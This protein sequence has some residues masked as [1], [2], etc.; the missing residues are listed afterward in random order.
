MGNREA[1]TI[2]PRR[3]HPNRPPTR[4]EPPMTAERQE[5]V[6]PS[7]PFLAMFLALPV[8]GLA[9]GP[10]YAA[11][12]FG[13]A[14]ALALLAA[15]RHHRL[16]A[17]D[18][19]FG[20]LALAFAALASAGTLWSIVPAHTAGAAA[21]IALILTA[22]LLVLATPLPDPE[23][24]RA[25]TRLLPWTLALGVALLCVDTT[26]GYPFQKLA[27]LDG[28]KYSRG[29]DYLVLIAWPLLAH[30][31]GER[32]WPMA[33]MVAALMAVAVTVGVSTTGALALMVGAAV[34]IF[35]ALARQ[36]AGPALFALVAALVAALPF[37]LRAFAESRRALEPLLKTSGFHRL[38]IWDYMS[39]R[40][41]EQPL[42]GWG[43]LSAKS[44]PIRPEEL[45]GYRW[46][47]PGGIYPHNQWLELWLETGALGA[48]LALAFLALVFWRIRRRLPAAIQPFA[49]AACGSALII[50]WL[51]F[52]ITTDSWWA[53][54]AAS[55]LLFRLVSALPP[56]RPDAGCGSSAS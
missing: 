41:L 29:L 45:A 6:S 10:L 12:V 56:P 37:I 13:P 22:A 36:A 8:I 3:A 54:L 20:T 18:R 55:A 16:P 2:V 26:L 23:A 14:G 17:I 25:L 31:V 38:E 7:V 49:Y 21:Q 48:A 43:L 42:L 9:A 11:L 47:S 5:P 51:N 19:G 4:T 44:V 34:L 39:A 30:F 32:R 35:A 15:A 53:A 28:T 50:S 33:A 1:S 27:G 52:E 40:I 46:V 24:C